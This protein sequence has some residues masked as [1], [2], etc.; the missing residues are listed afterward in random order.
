LALLTVLGPWETGCT[1]PDQKLP[2]LEAFF[3]LV[4]QVEEGGAFTFEFG[5]GSLRTADDRPWRGT[6]SFTYPPAI[7]LGA[8]PVRLEVRGLDL[9]GIRYAGMLGWPPKAW[10]R[11]A[12]VEVGLI[13][14]ARLMHRVS[15][16]L[17]GR[18]TLWNG[19]ELDQPAGYR[20][21]RVEGSLYDEFVHGYHY[22]V[23]P[24]GGDSAG[25]YNTL[26]LRFE[27]EDGTLSSWVRL[28]ASSSWEAGDSVAGGACP[29]NPSV[30]TA[31]AS[32]VDSMW[33]G[34]C[35]PGLPGETGR[36]VGAWITIGSSWV[37]TDL[38]SMQ[39]HVAITNWAHA[40]GGD[41]VSWDNLVVTGT[42]PRGS[43]LVLARG[44]LETMGTARIAGWVPQG[45]VASFSFF[46]VLRSQGRLGGAWLHYGAPEIDLVTTA[47]DWV[48]DDSSSIAFGG[49]AIVNGGRGYRYEAWATIPEASDAPSTMSLRVI[50]VDGLPA[51]SAFGP[52]TD[53][54]ITR[55]TP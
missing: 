34:E 52:L 45:R 33:N 10:D 23:E 12:Y 2:D 21:Y 20:A 55:R 53:G 35:V 51:Y 31:V 9:S 4:Y 37:G 18:T 32:T 17:D 1:I 16:A 8:G 7:D 38:G 14:A 13:G 19:R 15:S 22:N 43:S 3:P 27:Y 5:P 46:T 6:D 26:D 29:W 54:I 24:V 40:S 41:E 44:R 48:I 30:K 28:H 11:G 39:P 25:G 47:S 50:T 49:D 42:P 36:T